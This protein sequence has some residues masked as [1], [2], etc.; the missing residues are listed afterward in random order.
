MLN[1]LFLWQFLVDLVARVTISLT[2]PWKS[3]LKLFTLGHIPAFP[4]ASNWEADYIS[5]FTEHAD[6]LKY[7]DREK[8]RPYSVNS[9]PRAAKDEI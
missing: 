6:L 5:Y 4:F 1:N 8:L 3:C 2:L 9:L 7:L